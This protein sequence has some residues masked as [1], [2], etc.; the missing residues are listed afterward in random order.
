MITIHK[1]VYCSR[2]GDELSLDEIVSVKKA[3]CAYCD[4][5]HSEALEIYG[6]RFKGQQGDFSNNSEVTY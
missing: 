5:M 6:Q 3:V 4:H 2:C 1:P